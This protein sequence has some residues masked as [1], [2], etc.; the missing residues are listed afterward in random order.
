[1]VTYS[2]LQTLM[3]GG[4]AFSTGGPG[5]GM[6]TRLYLNVLNKYDWVESAM[7]FNTQYTDTGLFGLYML[8]NPSKVSWVAWL[9]VHRCFGVRTAALSC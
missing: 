6:Y 7:A 9:Y 2:V 1:M 8:A 5:K 3:G 4:G